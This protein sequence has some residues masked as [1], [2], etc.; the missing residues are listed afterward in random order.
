MIEM[1][2]SWAGSPS[3]MLVVAGTEFNSE[4]FAEFAQANNIKLTTISPEAS[5]SEWQG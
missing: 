3:E 2:F 1:W 5:V 4:E